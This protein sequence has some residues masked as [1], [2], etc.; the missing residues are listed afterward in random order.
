MKSINKFK[1]EGIINCNESVNLAKKDLTISLKNLKLK[2][3]V[4][5]LIESNKII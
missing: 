5:D 1:K 4:I 3:K 2:Q